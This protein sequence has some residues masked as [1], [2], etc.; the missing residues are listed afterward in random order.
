MCHVSKYATVST[1]HQSTEIRHKSFASLL[2]MFPSV[3]SHGNLVFIPLKNRGPKLSLG[4][5]HTATVSLRFCY[6]TTTGFNW[7]LENLG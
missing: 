2:Y 5:T 1:F 6:K 3:P 7:K 4:G